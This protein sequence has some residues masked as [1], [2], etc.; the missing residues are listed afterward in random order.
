MT[1]TSIDTRKRRNHLALFLVQCI[2]MNGSVF[3]AGFLSVKVGQRVL[4]P[5]FVVS[6]GTILPG[7]G[8]PGFLAVLRS[9]NGGRST[10]H[11]V[12]QLQG[13]HQVRVPDQRLV[14]NHNVLVEFLDHGIDLDHAVLEG[15]LVPI[16]GGV[17]LHGLLELVADFRGGCGSFSVAKV[18]EVL[19]GFHSL[20][21]LH[22]GNGVAGFV[23]LGNL[24]RTGSAKDH[25]VQ[26]GIGSQSVGP[27]HAG[28]GHLS[29]G[30]ESRN[31]FVADPCLVL[32]LGGG[33]IVGRFE[34]LSVVIGWDSSHVVVDRG[35]G[36]NGFLGDI[37][38]GKNGGGFGNSRQSFRQQIGGQVIEVQVD[39]ILFGS[40]APSLPNFHRHCPRD[41]VPRGQIL[42]AGSIPFHKTLSLRVAQDS[43][44]PTAALRHETSGP[45]DSGGMELHKLVVLV[46]DSLAQ[47]HGVSIARAGVCRSTGKVG[48]SVSA[49]GQH[50]VLGPDSVYGPVFHVEANDPD[51]FAAIV[52]HE[53]VQAEVLDEI[54]RVKGQ[55]AS[56]Q[57]VEHG[58]AGS[59]GR[60]ATPVRLAAFSE[61]QRLPPKRP[62]VD[63]AVFRSGKGHSEGFQ[64]HD[65][66]GGLPAHVVNGVLIA[67]P[68]ASLHG[69]VHV[70]PPVV[71]RHVSESGVDSSLGRN[72]V[73]SRW[74]QFRH[75]GGLES[76]L[77]KAHG[78]T[79]SASSGTDHH[80]VVFVVYHRIVS[81]GDGGSSGR[82]R[83]RGCG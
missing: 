29:G 75:A 19:Q 1:T 26:E 67:E 73:G 8:P 62:L 53:Q 10:G 12:L 38:S 7:V 54:G 44:L 31:G 6:I 11:Q 50:R 59:I 30:K 52:R 46:G 60:G 20:V 63:L 4:H 56:V 76:G 15:L 41:N 43:T 74:E 64:F 33:V 2:G 58:V 72:R 45:V 81:L 70:P 27:V 40:N 78:G 49:G 69:V 16:H 37:D 25:N 65:R 9:G 18:V 24:E 51:A 83:G 55:R 77:G 5:F 21:L 79:Q 48:P 57:G 80:G 66:L 68:I 13:F 36:G 82:G 39:V 3:D 22:G 23:V 71:F 35:Q 34:D 17:F 61:L 28:G 47:G 14:R 32:V 42:G